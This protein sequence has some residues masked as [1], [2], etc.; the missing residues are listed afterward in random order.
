MT[1]DISQAQA[2]QNLYESG[3]ID[4]VRKIITE[5]GLAFF[6]RKSW[7]FFWR[8]VYSGTL[9]RFRSKRYF[10]FG[11][12][13]YEWFCH[14]YNF[15]WDN[16]R[17]V[18]VPIALAEV[19]KY[20]GKRVLEAGN[21]L[22]HYVKPWWDILD[23]FERKNGVICSDI[24]DYHPVERYDLILSISTIEHVGFDDDVQDP[25]K[26]VE[27][28]RSLRTCCLAPDGLLLVTI[29]L[30]Y[31]PSLDEKLFAGTLGFDDVA[32]MKRVSTGRW[33]EVSKDELGDFSYGTRY[34]EASVVAFAWA[35]GAPKE[36]A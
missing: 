1:D 32:Y 2:S 12:N 18:E 16:E 35:A 3:I 4:R 26:P 19:E 22:S 9:L 6:I 11:D 28:I 23:K 30:G 36:R 21:V 10:Y 33:L 14:P 17:A 7:V 25:E 15:T 34:I 24:V 20:R 13:E 29:P 8:Y 5:K 27:A 31:N